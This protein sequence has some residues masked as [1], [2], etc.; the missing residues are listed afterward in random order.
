MSPD[1]LLA[2]ESEFSVYDDLKEKLI[3]LGIP[4]NEIAFIHDANTDIR[5]EELFAR[6]RS[7]MVRVL[8]GSTSK[9]GAGMNV[10]ER[11][12]ALH[13]LD[14]PWR[15]SDLEQREGRIIRQGNKLFDKDPQGFEIEILRY[16]TKQTLDSRMWQTLETKARFIEQVRKGTGE[17]Q[18]ED[19]GGEAANSAEMK[20]ASSGNPLILEEMTLRKTIRDLE[21]Q[22]YNHERSQHRIRDLI[23]TKNDHIK[24]L[25][26]R[27]ETMG[28][29]VNL[30][31]QKFAATI[32]G[33]TYERQGEI[34]AAILDA[35]EKMRADK[36]D[37]VEIG[38][39][40]GYK[41]IIDDA[42]TKLGG[43]QAILTIKGK[44]EYQI[45]ANP[46]ASDV[47][48]GIRLRN[49]VP[50]L[51]KINDV[52]SEIKEEKDEV[53]KLES[54]AAPW[55]KESEL[56]AGKG[57]H[58]AIIEELK[59]KT[60]SEEKP[61]DGA[62]KKP[63]EKVAKQEYTPEQRELAQSHANDFGGEVAWQRG[64]Y[65][66]IRAY[67]SADGNPVYLAAWGEYRSK[68]DV[69]EYTGT[70][71]ASDVK[72]E[73]IAAKR[74]AKAAADKKHQ[75]APFITF[76]D[77]VAMSPDIPEQLAGVIKDWKSMLKLDV[78]IYVS[79]IEDARANRNNFTGPHRSIGSGT[80]DLSFLGRTRMMA[81]GGHY[82]LFR[83]STSTTKMLEVIAHEM[84]HIHEK[85]Y[86]AR[87]TL[88]EK[89]ALYREHRKWLEEQKGKTA[90]EFVDS[91]RARST[92]RTI[93]TPEGM[94]ASELDPYWS[95]FKEWYS[96]QTAR[97]AMS[98]ER[99]V[100]IVEKYF[101]RLGIQL[102]RF[103]QQL[104]AKKYLPNE[105]FAEYIEKATSRP[106]NIPL[107]NI[108]VDLMGKPALSETNEFAKRTKKE[109]RQETINQYKELR[110][111]LGRLPTQ[112]AKGEVGL[113]LQ[114]T[115]TE[116]LQKTSELK[117]EIETTKPRRDSAEVFLAKALTEY[118]NGN[119]SK[120]VLDVVQASYQK[121]PALLEGLQLSVVKPEKNGKANARFDPVDRIV[122]LFKETTGA[123]NPATIRH[124]LTHSLEQ[125]MTP[126]QQMVVVQ[127]WLKA[128]QQAIKKYPEEKHQDYLRAVLNFFNEPNDINYQ[129]ALDILPN[130]EMYQFLNPSEYWAIN[131]EKLLAAELGTAWDKFKRA[132]RQLW[133]G[134]KKV[135]GFDNR[136]DVHK[137]FNQVMG[138]GMERI[139]Y[140]SIV[141]GA[142][143]NINEYSPTLADI[144]DEKLLKKYS[145]PNTPT[146]SDETIKSL[147]V[148]SAVKAK[149][150]FKDAVKDPKGAAAKVGNTLTDAILEARNQAVFY[151]AGLEARDFARYGGELRTAQELVTASVALDNAIRSGNIAQEVLFRG[152]IRYNPA[153]GMYE[154]VQTKKGMHGVYEA[155]KKLLD[156]LGKQV[157]TD[158]IQGYLEAKRSI[159]ITNEY[160]DRESKYQGALA[161]YESALQTGQD[162]QLIES[163][164]M[165]ADSLQKDVEQ[166]KKALSSVNMSDEEMYAFAALEDK[167][168]EL[169]DIMDNWTAVSQNLL[170]MW[171]DVKL[172]PKER[173]N[174]LSEIKDY[175][176]WYRI[177]DD[178]LD[179]HDPDQSAPKTTTRA[180]TNIGREKL[181]KRG[182][183]TAVLDFRAK[184]GQK[185]F[186]IQP[187]SSVEV[188]VN[189]VP[190]PQSK[191]SVTAD[192]KVTINLPLKENDL[193]VIKTHREIQNIID[194]MTNNVM[195]MT[196]NGLRQYAANRIVMEYASRNQKGKVM[197]FPKED[198]NKGRFAWMLN[199]KKVFVEIQDPLVVQ[200][201]YG[202]ENM[203]L[204]M[205]APMAAVAN[206]TRRSITL[207]PAFQVAQ[208]FKD[209]PTAALVT[210]VK[211]PMALI[212]GVWKG[213]ITSLT[214]TEPVAEI[215]KAAGIGGYYSPARTADDE[216]KR[217]LGVMNGNV[218][219]KFI[220]A[221]DHISDASDMAQRVAVYKRVMAETNDEML[222]KYQAANVF[223]QMRH[224]ASPY[225]QLFTRT[226]PFANAYAVT[227]DKLA[228]TLMGGGLKGMD[229]KKA[230]ARLGVCASMLAGISL[231]YAMA[232]GGDPEYEEL[233]DQTKLKNFMI[234]GTKIMLPMNTAAAYFFKAIPEL[235]YNHITKK[236]TENEYD[237]RRLRQALSGVAL[238]ALSG[239]TPIPIAIKPLLEVSVDYS[240][241][242]GRSIVPTNL[243]DVEAA[244]QYTGSTSELGKAISAALEIP[245]TDGKRVLNPIEAD[246]IVRGL[247]GTVGAMTQWVTNSIGSI[248]ETRPEPSGKENPFIGT[249]L[250]EEVPR[251][252]E[253]LYYD[254]KGVV[255]TKYQTWKKMMERGAY[256]E[257]DAF[258]DKNDAAIS[259]HDYIRD[260]DAE[261]KDINSEIRQLGESKDQNLSPKERRK[262]IDEYKRIK[263]EILDPV[264]DMRREIF[265]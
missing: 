191:L 188:E 125:M 18:A 179:M 202:M 1:D 40:G 255:D 49:A 222:A 206:L 168:T 241:F 95:L 32:Y 139:N 192:G 8:L 54:Q 228:Q 57:R 71:L 127:S 200:A 128:L 254:L 2:L 13:H 31:P 207:S 85:T 190:V 174:S 176:P 77:G 227:I 248:A 217:R 238:D 138:G 106:E 19:I 130:Y 82:I 38:S 234:P 147:A 45:D 5:K 116:L 232:V 177:M 46:D 50:D 218:Y 123:V 173:Y 35:A 76:Q 189:D 105:T 81:D 42:S 257:A 198:R 67:S 83:K 259:M 16:A 182:K 135:F 172:I 186:K 216:V 4:A 90:R 89:D 236:G 258:L 53:V 59:P 79:T 136:Y 58:A 132:V 230:L 114:K 209:A 94:L 122:A 237:A 208:V 187:S 169:R 223:N 214:G 48:L 235:V 88:V 262:E 154:A 166:I 245:G 226:I 7:G 28:K 225:A 39:Y 78:P 137:V 229:R 107:A 167:H 143:E 142:V 195:R 97:W 219:D 98:S 160:L 184:A 6:V 10:Q 29:D 203:N 65:A 150:I 165:L 201:I 70:G 161:A 118:S 162:L 212:G 120:E 263:N 220:R 185:E 252:K 163:F 231:L 159:S 233:D 63:I 261:L 175:V 22:R 194:N 55:D 87:A 264:K 24:S 51:Q 155:Q 148:D 47:G 117:R 242:T 62:N 246:H 36:K 113:D 157:G 183:P 99:P 109:I 34:G 133:E 43:I 205:F 253:D 20:A 215:L 129:T 115:V 60:K 124:E 170:K 145:R 56:Q 74:E 196:I 11:L 181:F 68:V 102:R 9:M 244:E 260:T 103:F 213:F 27:A 265:Q 86:F 64:E 164:K 171:K 199:G 52:R 41:L 250:R 21:T 14:A 211:N 84:G 158:I 146:T 91:M 73:M 210:G 151:G 23:R 121:E 80:L 17:R 33:K 204:K 100:S 221:L 126:D 108:D 239:P 178:G 243:K 249:F 251:G 193:V 93:K 152:G 25:E 66:L 61:V 111:K 101:K 240:F 110:A 144:D 30:A 256:E 3:A 75:E 141:Q 96:D 156:K 180:M 149:K 44:E 131:A 134:L 112:I 140:S 92:G 119:I 153:S 224:G 26:K 12:V 104:K 15:P 37:S 72:Q 69:E 247:F 197:L